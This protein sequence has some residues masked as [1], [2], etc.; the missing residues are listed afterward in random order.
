MSK[1]KKLDASAPWYE[2]CHK[3][4]ALFDGDDDVTVGEYDDDSKT[5]KVY[6]RGNDKADALAKIIRTPVELGNVTINVEVVPDN[7]V[8]PTVEDIVHTALNGNPLFLG[9][10]VEELYGGNATYVVFEPSVIQY[11]NDNIGSYFGFETK[12]AED[13]AKDVLDIN[14]FICTNV[15]EA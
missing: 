10:V 1:E 14:A 4:A 8:E 6:V 13:V 3:L 9:T 12:T 7:D 5:V 2:H 15:E 11:W